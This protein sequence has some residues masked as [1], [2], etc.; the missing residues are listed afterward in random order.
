MPACLQ[1]PTR[2]QCSALS[3]PIHAR[4]RPLEEARIR[5]QRIAADST[6]S[7]IRNRMTLLLEGL[8]E[9]RPLSSRMYKLRKKK[10]GTE[11]PRSARLKAG[12][13]KRRRRCGESRA[14]GRGRA[15]ARSSAGLKA[16]EL[17]SLKGY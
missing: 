6:N 5:I 12:S 7:L 9:A 2:A 14:P 10:R 13:I 11:T 15:A 16:A 3:H 17:S 4:R 1:Y 8:G